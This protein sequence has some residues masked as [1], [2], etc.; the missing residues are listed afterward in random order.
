METRDIYAIMKI[1]FT[2]TQA[3]MSKKQK[4]AF[5][6]LLSEIDKKFSVREFH[7]GDCIGADEESFD[8]VKKRYGSKC[9]IVAH[10]Q[11]TQLKELGQNLMRLEK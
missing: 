6:S 4:L 2:G 11:R 7:H 1:G 9:K 10:H 5:I 3:G 8:I